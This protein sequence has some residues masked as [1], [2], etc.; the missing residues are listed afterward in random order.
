MSI[1]LRHSSP[2][3]KMQAHLEDKDTDTL[4]VF[5]CSMLISNGI[6]NY[7]VLIEGQYYAVNK[8]MLA[9]LRAGHSPEELGLEP[10]TN[11]TED[12]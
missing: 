3:R 4:K 5:V 7:T 2:I 12:E 1:A 11:D 9:D 6:P 10:S 8:Y